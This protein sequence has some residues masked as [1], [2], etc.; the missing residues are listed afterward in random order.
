MN[1][2]IYVGTPHVCRYPSKTERAQGPPG[3]RVTGDCKP[4]DVGAWG[5]TQSSVRVAI[6]LDS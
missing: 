3:T 6:T 5:R 4:C 2:W 1:S